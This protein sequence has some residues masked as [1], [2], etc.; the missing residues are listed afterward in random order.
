MLRNPSELEKIA[1]FK[2]YRVVMKDSEVASILKVYKAINTISPNG[3]KANKLAV[4]FF[5]RIIFGE[6][7]DFREAELQETFAVMKMI[8]AEFMSGANIE[9]SLPQHFTRIRGNK[10]LM[11]YFIQ[12]LLDQVDS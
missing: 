9:K 6:R 10:K 12:E 1:G 4:R 3:T 2:E 11:Q 7:R 8:V 5:N